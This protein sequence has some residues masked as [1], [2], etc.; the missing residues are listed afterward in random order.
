MP[1]RRYHLAQA[2]Q[3]KLRLGKLALPSPKN[4]RPGDLSGGGHGAHKQ[5]NLF[6]T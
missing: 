5:V 6:N 4:L 3:I 2:L 1:C